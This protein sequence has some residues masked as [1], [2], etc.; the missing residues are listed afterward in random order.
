MSESLTGFSEKRYS[1]AVI[2]GYYSTFY[3]IKAAL[4]LRGYAIIR[5]KSLYHLKVS[6]GEKLAR[7]G[8]Y[9][10][11]H[12]T[13]ILCYKNFFPSDIL[14]SQEIENGLLSHEWLM[15]KR[16]QVNYQERQFCEPNRPDFLDNID[17]KISNNEFKNLIGEIKKDAF[18]LTF[19][20]EFATIAIP[21]KRAL[22]TKKA[23]SDKGIVNI[24]EQVQ[25]VHLSSFRYNFV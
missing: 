10:G 19:Q 9:K 24:L 25:I 13:A 5:H 12:K 16:E 11:D 14:L 6:L 20:P 2:K 1:W 8:D 18:I 7:N 23:F 21:L 3:F 22:L 4:A 15:K 17:K